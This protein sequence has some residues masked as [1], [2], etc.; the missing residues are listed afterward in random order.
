[1]QPHWQ[2]EADLDR[3]LNLW[4]IAHFAFTL[5]ND[6]DLPPTCCAACATTCP[7]PSPS[8]PSAATGR[9]PK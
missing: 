9:R 7:C 5:E 3:L 6:H 1:M 4:T 2:K 8:P